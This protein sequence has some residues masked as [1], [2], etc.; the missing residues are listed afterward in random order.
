MSENEKVNRFE[1]KLKQLKYQYLHNKNNL[2][3]ISFGKVFIVIILFVL[4]LIF[5][6]QVNFLQAET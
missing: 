3:F 5:T 1:F 4:C 6:F 2:L